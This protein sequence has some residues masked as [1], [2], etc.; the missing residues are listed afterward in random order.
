MYTIEAKLS[1]I[2]IISAACFDTSVPEIP[3]AIPNI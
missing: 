2:K 1:F 3:I